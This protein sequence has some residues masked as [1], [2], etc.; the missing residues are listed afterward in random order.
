MSYLGWNGNFTTKFVSSDVVSSRL[1]LLNRGKI[2][3]SP[4]M[5]TEWEI[6]MEG[7]ELRGKNEKCVWFSSTDKAC[8]ISRHGLL[9]PT[10]IAWL[11]SCILSSDSFIPFLPS[12]LPS[13]LCARNAATLSASLSQFRTFVL[14]RILR[15]FS[16]RVFLGSPELYTFP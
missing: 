11:P 15:I 10:A 16:I 2:K 12:L 8:L 9:F 4:K 6:P 14:F 13:F 3:A 5:E 1:V 7:R